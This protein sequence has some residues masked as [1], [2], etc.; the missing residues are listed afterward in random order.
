MDFSRSLSHEHRSAFMKFIFLGA[1][2]GEINLKEALHGREFKV[3]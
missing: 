2:N 3:K 1:I